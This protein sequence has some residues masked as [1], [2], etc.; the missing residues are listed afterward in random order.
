[1]T[2]FIDRARIIVKSG[3]GGNGVVSFHHAKYV[4]AGGPD[5]G[6]GGRGGEAL[7]FQSAG[8]IE[9][10]AIGKQ[11]SGA[12]VCVAG[13]GSVL[14]VERRGGSTCFRGRGATT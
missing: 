4:A 13:E 5:G 7:Y 3:A 9:R 8:N 11:T 12:F 10:R 2:N 6:D 1:M 14:S